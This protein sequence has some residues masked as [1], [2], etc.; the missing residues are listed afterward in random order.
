MSNEYP[1]LASLM[2]GLRER[3]P[4]DGICALAEFYLCSLQHEVQE[5]ELACG[6]WCE[7]YNNKLKDIE[8]YR[9]KL[10][11]VMEENTELQAKLEDLKK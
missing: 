9:K 6:D 2:K 3:A 10:Q 7:G 8:S 11:L 5:L 4:N 1:D